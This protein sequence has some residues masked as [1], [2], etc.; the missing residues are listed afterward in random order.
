MGDF[1]SPGFELV[2]DQL[3]ASAP[4]YHCLLTRFDELRIVQYS[5]GNE[6]CGATAYSG[7]GGSPEVIQAEGGR[8]Q[9][10]PVLVLLKTH[11]ENRDAGLLA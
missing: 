3:P 7:L 6:A 10:V 8:L 5:L 2:L 4:Q 1:D 11:L 9:Q